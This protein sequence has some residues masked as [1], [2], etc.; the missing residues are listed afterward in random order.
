MASKAFVP[1]AGPGA[2]G[3]V[4]P[5]SVEDV[6]NAVPREQVQPTPEG[7][8]VDLP[9]EPVADSPI[10]LAMRRKGF[11]PN[12][13]AQ[14]PVSSV[15]QVV[16]P[17]EGS[18]RQ[19]ETIRPISQRIVPIEAER[20]AADDFIDAVDPVEGAITRAN[21]VGN[22]FSAKADAE[23]QLIHRE[24]RPEIAEKHLAGEDVGQQVNVK[25]ILYS[26]RILG[27]AVPNP[28]T[29][30]LGVDPNLY[31]VLGLVTENFFRTS[32]Y[33]TSDAE[34]QGDFAEFDIEAQET[35]E[36]ADLAE[37]QG[38]TR[39][40]GNLRLGQDIWREWKR[41]QASL[42]GEPTDSYLANERAVSPKEFEVLG[43]LAKELYAR[44]NPNEIEVDRTGGQVVYTPT[45]EALHK[46]NKAHDAMSQPFAPVERKPL[47]QVSES[48]KYEHEGKILAR[49]VTT[50]V[51]KKPP[52]M[53]LID[54]A[55]YNLH[56]MPRIAD[57]KRE[58]L[59]YSLGLQALVQ[60]QQSDQPTPI[61][62]MFGIGNE[63]L[64]S[65]QGSKAEMQRVRDVA[66]GKDPN[67]TAQ[68]VEDARKKAKTQ[69]QID[70]F[71]PEKILK[72]EQKKFVES[73]NTISNYANQANYNTFYVQLLQGRLGMQQNKFNPQTNKAVRFV[74][75]SGNKVQINPRKSA[76]KPTQNFKEVAS[77]YL[78]GE[79]GD[80]VLAEAKF[81][82]PGARRAEFDRIYKSG[83]LDPYIK[84][85]NE[86]K[87]LYSPQKALEARQAMQGITVDET[88]NVVIPPQVQGADLG[89]SPETMKKIN[90][91]GAEGP[92]FAEF[93]MA[94]ADWD[95]AHKTG[96][97]FA[98]NLEVEMDGITHGPSSNA[99]ALGNRPMALRSGVLQMDDVHKL[100]DH[101]GAFGDLRAAMKRSL[102][103]NAFQNAATR[104]GEEAAPM[105]KSL[106]DKAVN[107]RENY[108]K[109][110]PMTLMY[111]QQIENLRQHVEAAV[112]SGPEAPGMRPELT[113]L[114]RQGLTVDDAVDFLHGELVDAIVLNLDQDGTILETL[115]L[116][117][118]YNVFSTVSDQPMRI[119]NSMGFTSVIGGRKESKEAR[120]QSLVNDDG[121]PV[122]VFRNPSS[123]FARSATITHYQDYGAGTAERRGV[124]GGYGH[125]RVV[126]ALVQQFDANMISRTASDADSFQMERK[127]KERGS[128][129]NLS[130]TPIFDAAK[131]DLA[132]M[133]LVRDRMNEN[134]YN[135]IRNY[136]YVE[137]IDNWAHDAFN[138]WWDETNELVK[139]GDQP[140]PLTLDG[141]YAAF[142]SWLDGTPGQTGWKKLAKLLQST[143]ELENNRPISDDKAFALTGDI[144]GKYYKK[145]QV[146]T[147]LKPSEMM[148]I[149]RNYVQV[150]RLKPRASNNRSKV[151][152]RR[153]ELFRDTDVRQKL[154][155]DLG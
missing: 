27:A 146:R 151:K 131:V 120:E 24:N 143:H 33:A 12:P 59:M 70:R 28:E 20:E 142:A 150:I 52:P 128:G 23:D 144:I 74:Y 58:A 147:E 155:V 11:N 135:G 41:E 29:G 122:D 5:L 16:P 64:V 62:D 68:Q 117:R 138:K 88:N 63:K 83:Q 37:K 49:D 149:M 66:D 25:D 85:G 118:A 137:E 3:G 9:V 1:T 136:D 134:W 94:L 154:Q 96:T 133:D 126:P 4:T 47:N 93:L 125:G 19:A 113:E 71:I 14:T 145:G 141:K 73:L 153:D 22:L 46:M 39:A 89:I 130:W 55:K 82:Q 98:T 57:G 72:L 77:M 124:V 21:N 78:F 61:A 119:K 7:G 115:Q 87:S 123:D 112:V 139:Q 121:Q 17:Q 91:H 31:P 34:V 132:H 105:L 90:E 79:L 53:K 15:D 95:Q 35:V 67:A 51:D 81:L 84:M 38:I 80:A 48:G 152:R 54:E 44:A 45:K 106:L 26:D 114:K 148:D 60:A 8:Q 18:Q 86:L 50:K 40:K 2:G 109:K 140:I 10:V 108:L 127:L 65:L 6:A 32:G 116:L 129:Y 102:Q 30:K 43:G 100:L 111:G 103:E 97:S 107:D 42:A 104:Y 36:D 69:K 92:Y 56:R 101:D 76:S 110:S 13:P 99:L 75:G